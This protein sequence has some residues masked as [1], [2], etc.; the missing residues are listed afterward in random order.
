MAEAEKAIMTT[1]ALSESK[2]S[3]DGKPKSISKEEVSGI[4]KRAEK[5]DEKCLS[6]LLAL[7]G[8]G[9]WG[10]FLTERYGSPAEW[11]ESRLILQSAGKDI[12]IREAMRQKLCQLRNDLA[13]A[14]PTPLERLLVERAVVC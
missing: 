1:E 2:P 4:L 11:V 9:T 13:G 14:S 6:E 7:L 3:S 8:D 12:A 5:G 10:K